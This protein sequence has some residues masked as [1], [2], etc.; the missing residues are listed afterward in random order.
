M[1]L[2]ILAKLSKDILRRIAEAVASMLGW[3]EAAV[4]SEI[5]TCRSG[6]CPR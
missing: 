3:D 5:E 2:L 1:P 6:P 4:V